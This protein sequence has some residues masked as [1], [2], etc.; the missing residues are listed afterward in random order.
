MLSHP[1]NVP[2]SV[3]SPN[4]EPNQD[5]QDKRTSIPREHGSLLKF[6]LISINIAKSCFP[7]VLELSP[8]TRGPAWNSVD[9]P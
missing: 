5:S 1:K 2:Q 3:S 7:W 9:E 4:H 8:M 6:L